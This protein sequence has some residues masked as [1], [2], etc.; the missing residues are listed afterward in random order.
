MSIHY[1]ELCSFYGGNVN[2]DNQSTD[3]IL[4]IFCMFVEWKD[5]FLHVNTIKKV[6]SIN[7]S[8]SYWYT[9]KF[10]MEYVKTFEL[11]AAIRGYHYY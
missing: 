1:R 7:S 10:A 9:K 5:V 8:E 6:S 11:T 2:N 4:R 3:T